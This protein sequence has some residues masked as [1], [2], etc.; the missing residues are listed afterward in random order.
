MNGNATVRD[1]V[2]SALESGVTD[3]R[4]LVT[5]VSQE[6]PLQMEIA[7]QLVCAEISRLMQEPSVGW[8]S[9]GSG[10]VTRLW[11]LPQH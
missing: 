3:A 5:L 8:E 6:P 7:S 11:L 2:R 9:D 4:T 10:T 1:L